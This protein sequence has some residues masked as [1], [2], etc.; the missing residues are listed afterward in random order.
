MGKALR[1]ELVST[2][3][4]LDVSFFFKKKI[5]IKKKSTS[6]KAYL[7]RGRGRWGERN[8]A[9]NVDNFKVDSDTS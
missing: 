5:E 1:P 7:K 9:L 2:E 3:T 8:E 6:K 4:V